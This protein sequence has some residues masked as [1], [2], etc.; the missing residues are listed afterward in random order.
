V[1]KD[2][3]SPAAH[4]SLVEREYGIPSVVGTADV[5]Y[6]LLTGQI[7]TVDGTVGTITLHA[8]A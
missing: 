4:A 3:G 2:S 5:T 7:V 6:Q 8:A 1:V